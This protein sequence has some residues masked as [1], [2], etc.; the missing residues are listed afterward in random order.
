MMKR[1]I[2]PGLLG[3]LTMILWTLVGTVVTWRLNPVVY[4][5]D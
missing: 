2:V 5:S 1:V 4:E 3:G